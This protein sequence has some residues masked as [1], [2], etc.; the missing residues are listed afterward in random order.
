[1]IQTEVK[2]LIFDD[3]KKFLV[4]GK[5]HKL[6]LENMEEN[7][8]KKIQGLLSWYQLTLVIRERP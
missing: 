6:I 5:S 7:L 1:M 4:Q 3:G 8:A 2:F